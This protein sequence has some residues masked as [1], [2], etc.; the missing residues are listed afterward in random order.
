MN[1][2]NVEKSPRLQRTLRVLRAGGWHSTRALMRAADICAVNSVVA[3]LRANGF[4]ID[5]RCVGRGRYEYQLTT[6]DGGPMTADDRRPMTADCRRPSLV[7]GRE[8]G[9]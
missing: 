7:C 5:T 1:Y 8:R 4:A 3:E 9:A 6:A 2:A